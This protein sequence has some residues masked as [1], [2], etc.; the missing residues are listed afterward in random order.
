MIALDTNVLVRFLIADDEA[1]AT[2][3][4]RLIKEHATPEIPAMITT[5][6]LVELFW[7][8]RSA[9]KLDRSAIIALI[10]GI[11][12]KAEFEF[13]HTDAALYAFQTYRTGRGDFADALLGRIARLNGC[14]T[15]YSF[16]SVAARLEDFSEL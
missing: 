6:V 4:A 15:T 10:D 5:V 12:T 11:L 3:A 8:L 7:V 9:Y 16:D 13:E 2:R 1:Q 14:S